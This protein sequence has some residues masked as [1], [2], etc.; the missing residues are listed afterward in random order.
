MIPVAYYPTKP[1]QKGKIPLDTERMFGY[2]DSNY[3][4]QMSE[5]IS[6]SSG[7]KGDDGKKT[8][9]RLER[10]AEENPGSA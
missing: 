4:A 3:L 8:F 2:Y 10:T 7:R 9:Q 6:Q 1:F 5:F